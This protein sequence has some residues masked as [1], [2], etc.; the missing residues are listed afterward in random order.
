MRY[1]WW[2]LF[3]VL[4]VSLCG[5][6]FYSFYRDVRA[7][8][9]RETNQRQMVLA[10]QAALGIED[11]F[12]RYNRLL[13]QLA[14]EEE[15][16]SLSRKGREMM[17]FTYRS[18]ADEIR[19]ITRMDARGRI[20]YTVP[21]NKDAIGADISTQRHVQELMNI[22]IPVVSEV[23]TAVQGMSAIAYHVPVFDG[24]TFGGSIGILLPFDY[25]ARK[26]LEQIRVGETGYA[27]MI[28]REGIELYCPV[29]GHTGRPVTETCRDF[30]EILAMATSMMEGREGTAAYTYDR[31]RDTKVQRVVKHAVYVPVKLGNTFWSIVVATPEDEIVAGMT[32]FRNRLLLIFAILLAGSI[33]FSFSGFR[34]W[35]IIKG[36]KERREA[37]EAL[38]ESEAR[39]RAIFETTGTAT[40]IIENDTT[41]SLANKEFENLTGYTREEIEGKMRWID[42]VFPEDLEWMRVRHDRRRIDPEGTERR[43]EFR[44]VNRAGA[45]RDI[46]LTI[47][48]IPGTRK[49]VASLL[50]ITEAKA[51]QRA[52]VE[53]EEKYR[54][55][56]ENAVEGIFRSVPEG[57]FVSVNPSLA[58]MLGYDSP[59]EMIARIT[60]IA[61]QYC[62]RAED[63]AEYVRLLETQGVAENFESEV[64]RKD[65]S[66]IWVSINARA[67]KDEAGTIRF[68]E[69]TVENITARK[70]GEKEKAGLEARL[71]QAQKMEAIGTLAGG[72]AHDFNNLLMAIQGY[73]FL[74]LMDM[75]PSNPLYERVRGIEEA[76]KSGA[77]LT[78]QLLGFA[79]GGRYEVKTTDLNSLI[80]KVAEMFG[81]TRKEIVIHRRCAPRLLPADVDQ[82]QIEQV[83]L[84]LFLNAWQAM[85]GGGTITVTTENAVLKDDEAARAEVSPGDYVR[86]TIDDT[87]EGMDEKTRERIFEPFF[88]TRGMGRGTGLGLASAYGIVRGHQGCIGVRSEPGSGTTFFILL[89]A[90]KGEIGKEAVEESSLTR[91]NEMILLVDDEEAILKVTGEGLRALGYRVIT[92]R[93]G[94]EAVDLYKTNRDAVDLVILDM[95][96]PGMGGKETFSRLR[97]VDPSVKVILS[98]GY[99]IDGQARSIMEQ[100]CRAFI[101]KPFHLADLSR[102]VREVLEGAP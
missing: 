49:S 59:G 16:I 64:F 7:N 50:D 94:T 60:S 25:L 34:A 52:L 56:F 20:L 26:Y 91:G 75:D 78:R 77:G 6:L 32:G 38:K 67:V 24:A 40:V 86:I 37:E 68:Y 76:V 28:S 66:T 97:E 95:I 98:S 1:K 54:S 41:I 93:S 51:A 46:L 48:L 88:T 30:P 47:D 22:R 18:H 70:E 33:L 23:F 45:L 39:Y 35:A 21:F 65:G 102:K 3:L 73:A 72:I 14:G 81:R 83:I 55:I 29:P 84:N 19:G 12:D 99:S 44:L 61:D 53:S 89:P 87:G 27:W 43:Y 74:T 100:G 42:F 101:Q 85:P 5:L 58:R 10:R 79:R 96:M 11:S 13:S 15:I 71:R 36:E 2:F 4:L 57:R 62:V 63:R 82:G 17:E 92:A 31:V 9:I 90:S 69:G 80:E 8:I